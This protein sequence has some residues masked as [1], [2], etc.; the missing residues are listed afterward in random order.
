MLDVEPA[1]DTHA[2]GIHSSGPKQTI[3]VRPED[4]KLLAGLSPDELKDVNFLAFHNWDNTR[5]FI[6]ALDLKAGRDCHRRREVGESNEKKLRVLTRDFRAALDEPGEWFLSR[7]GTLSYKPRP[8]EDIA[9]ASVI[10]P[11]AERFVEIRG[12]PSGGTF[13]DHVIFKGLAFENGQWL[14]PRSGIEPQQ[15]AAQIEA[16][17]I[18]DGARDVTFED[19]EIAHIGTYAIWFRQGCRN[20]VIRHC[21]LHDLGAGG[22]R[23]GTPGIPQAEAERTSGIRIDNNIIRH[24][25]RIFPC[26]VGVWIGQASDNQVTHNEI[27]DLFYTGVSVGWTWGY[28]PSLAARN[29]IEFNHIHHIAW[30]MMSD[31]GG[32]YTLGTS[33]GTT[34]S[35]NVIHDISDYT[36]GGWGLYADEGSSGIVMENN[37]VYNTQSAGF[38]QHYG[39]DNL[40]RNNIF[41]FNTQA[42]LQR[43]R[44]SPTF[45]SPL[46]TT[47]STG[48]TASYLPGRG[49]TRA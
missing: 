24:G 39:Q 42:Q 35:N 19:C 29:H 37:L 40:I 46:R 12:S 22:V 8:G 43:T 27:A 7:R 18:A 11:I 41:A 1:S 34:V 6:E 21:H 2:N 10:A 3:F 36:Y 4:L 30:R 17:V 49:R 32:V 5:K 26:A 9:H 44:V 16:A 14:T 47:W 25:G 38:H 33:P 45:P 48:E 23:V 28:G 20:D 31:L 13:V 15:A